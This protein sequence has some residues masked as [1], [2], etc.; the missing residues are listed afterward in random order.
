MAKATLYRIA[1]AGI[2]LGAVLSAVSGGLSPSGSTRAAIA[3]GLYYPSTVMGILGGLL[4]IWSLWGFFLRQ[5]ERGGIVAFLGTLLVIAGGGTLLVVTN[6]VMAMIIPWVA[7]QPVSNSALNSG[8]AAVT[9]RLGWTLSV[10]ASTTRCRR[11]V[12][13]IH[14]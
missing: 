4:L 3:S 8:P 10:C 7:H 5:S 9:P 13:A 2:F 11:L 6:I 12:I 1:A 14:R